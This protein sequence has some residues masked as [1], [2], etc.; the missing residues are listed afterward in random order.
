MTKNKV[1]GNY[2]SKE[3]KGQIQKM[4]KNKIK[5]TQVQDQEEQDLMQ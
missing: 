4:K 2:L 3:K 5:I 1:I